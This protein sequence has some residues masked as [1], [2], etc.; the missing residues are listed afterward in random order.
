MKNLYDILGIKRDGT[1]NEGDDIKS[2]FMA[3][4]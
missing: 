3:I 4:F 2:I 1:N